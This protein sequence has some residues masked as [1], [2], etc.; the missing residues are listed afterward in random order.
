MKSVIIIF[1]LISICFKTLGQ[2]YFGQSWITGGGN[3]YK[4]KFENQQN[5]ISVFD[6][7]YNFYFHLGSSCISDSNGNL[8]IICDGYDLMDTLGNIIDN[9]DTLVPQ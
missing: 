6:T 8:K 1:V 9:G 7:N 2:S 4:V 3:S 5:T